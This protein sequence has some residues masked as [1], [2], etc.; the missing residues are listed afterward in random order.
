MGDSLG[1][2][3]VS[4]TV[5]ATLDRFGNMALQFGVNL[6]LARLLLPVDFGAIGVLAIFMAVAQVLTDGG[7]SSALIQRNNLTQTDYSSI[8]FCNLAM[9]VVIYGVLFLCAPYIAVFFD[10]PVLC[11]VLRCIGLIIIISGLAQVQ[12]VRFK[13]SMAFRTIAL[14]NLVSYALAGAVAVVMAKQGYGVWSLVAMMIINQSVMSLLYWVLSS[15]RPS[16]VFSRESFR[17]LF[18][19]GGYLLASS[20]LQEICRNM[21]GVIIG[22]RF[23]GADMGYYSQAYK[24]DQVTSYAL[25][26]ALVQVLFPFFSGIS[27]DRKRLHDM[28]TIGIR[29]IA[30]F[31]FPMLMLL[32]IVAPSLIP[33]LWG[34]KWIP[35]VP[36]FRIFCVGGLFTCL[37]NVNF[38]AVAACGFSKTLFRWSFYKWGMLLALMFVGMFFGMTGLL[39]AISISNFNIYAVN[40]WLASHHVGYKLTTQIRTIAPGMAASLMSLVVALIAGSYGLHVMLQ[41]AVFIAV[42]LC[43]AASMRMPVLDSIRFIYKKVIKKND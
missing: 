5:W 24:L 6:L 33:W 17:T 21:Q 12:L 38:Y 42:Y 14:V 19:Y 41:I 20:L 16:F 34:D 26:Q 8:F 29:L 15:W 3:V 32:I 22:R 30:T 11:D 13:K 10:M 31:I 25:P 7:F 43:C 23:S 18:G 9:S 1:K 4:G 35:C 40:A 36:Y 37:Q 27:D 39:W 28:M 2:K